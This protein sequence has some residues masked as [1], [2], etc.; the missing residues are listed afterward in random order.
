MKP[1]TTVI[2]NASCHE[3]W[4]QHMQNV[5]AVQSVNVNAGPPSML[6]QELHRSRESPE[7]QSSNG[8]CIHN[9]TSNENW[10]A[11][12]LQEAWEAAQIGG[13][14]PTQI[15]TDTDQTLVDYQ[16][17]VIQLDSN[18][19]PSAPPGVQ[20]SNEQY[21]PSTSQDSI[22]MLYSLTAAENVS[23][24]E[25]GREAEFPQ[26]AME[27]ARKDDDMQTQM[28]ANSNQRVVVYQSSL[29]QMES[30]VSYPSPCA[31]PMHTFSVQDEKRCLHGV[32]G[33]GNLPASEEVVCRQLLTL[34]KEVVMPI[35]QPQSS[36]TSP[37]FSLWSDYYNEEKEQAARESRA[38]VVAIKPTPYR[39]HRGGTTSRKIYKQAGVRQLPTTGRKTASG[40]LANVYTS[41]NLVPA[42]FL[43]HR[44]IGKI[45]ID[46][47]PATPKPQLPTVRHLPQRK[48]SNCTRLEI[49]CRR[50]IAQ[51]QSSQ[52]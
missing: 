37:L 34:T 28:S 24:W 38:E 4:L 8:E 21:T 33:F 30:N 7:V 25:G 52:N 26:E 44:P 41:L 6:P 31:F 48:Q 47:R 12:L 22:S 35:Q 13:D 5:V 20:Y 18:F 9:T 40:G 42:S 10:G 51:Q 11:D 17:S 49:A 19:S 23:V 2:E 1:S 29:V 43:G 32:S 15:P 16:S 45:A 3:E 14:T 39:P 46:V 50:L 36:V 27:T